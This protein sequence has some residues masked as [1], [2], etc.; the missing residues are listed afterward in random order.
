MDS[1]IQQAGARGQNS[2][3]TIKNDNWGLGTR[4][5]RTSAAQSGGCL[6]SVLFL[7]VLHW[8]FGARMAIIGKWHGDLLPPAPPVHTPM[9]GYHKFSVPDTVSYSGLQ[10]E[11][12]PGIIH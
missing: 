12:R 3:L 6:V 11:D 7:T 8:H 2:S 5:R 1:Q 4:H 9:A 10:V